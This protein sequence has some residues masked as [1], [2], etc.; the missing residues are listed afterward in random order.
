MCDTAFTDFQCVG[1]PLNRVGGPA[2]GPRLP[3]K[4]CVACVGTFLSTSYHAMIACT[5]DSQWAG[6]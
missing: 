2:D 3:G 6:T 5:D 1:G 4:D